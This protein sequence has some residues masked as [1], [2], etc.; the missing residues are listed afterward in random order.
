MLYVRSFVV[1][2]IVL[3]CSRGAPVPRVG[4]NDEHLAPGSF[5]QLLA[6]ETAAHPRRGH[7][8]EDNRSAALS[9]RR[10]RG[11]F[12]MVTGNPE[13]F[14]EED[15]QNNENEEDTK[16]ENPARREVVSQLEDFGIP[17]IQRSEVRPLLRSYAGSSKGSKHMK[18]GFFYYPGKRKRPQRV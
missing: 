12:R 15:L 7:N 17:V 3:A 1:M 10:L 18:A 5:N 6:S 2:V 13:D 14:Q 4:E 9:K 8:K 11:H 16:P